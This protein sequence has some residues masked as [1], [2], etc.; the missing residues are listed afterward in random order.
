VLTYG[1]HAV[2]TC[3]IP[4]RSAKLLGA[5]PIEFPLAPIRAAVAAAWKLHLV[6]TSPT[7]VDLALSLPI[8]DTARAREE[9]EW[10]PTRTSLDAIRE[11]LEG[12]KDG[13]GMDTPPLEPLAGGRLR[14]RK[15][16]PASGSERHPSQA[17]PW[18]LP[19]RTRDAAMDVRWLQND[20]GSN[21]MSS[22]AA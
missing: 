10:N 15:W 18:H 7:L 9:L 4:R 22:I 3:S 11:F 12:L 5:R 14:E 6:P 13:S 21:S 17:D 19:R 8:M 16:R 1:G 2:D 20:S